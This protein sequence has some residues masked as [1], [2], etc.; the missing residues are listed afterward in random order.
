MGSSDYPSNRFDLVGW[1]FSGPVGTLPSVP[2]HIRAT[3]KPLNL[4]IPE[5]YHCDTDP[6]VI[7]CC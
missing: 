6:R 4:T 7:G 1:A 2:T 3:A 5:R